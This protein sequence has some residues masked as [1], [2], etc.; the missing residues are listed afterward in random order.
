MTKAFLGGTCNHS[1]W[2]DKLI[3]I[4]NID[5]FNPVVKEWDEIAQDNEIYQR[6]TCDYVLY[7]ITPKMSG[8]YSIAE[9]VEDSIKRPKKTIFCFIENDAGFI[10]STHQI[11]SLNAVADMVKRNGAMYLSTLDDVANFLNNSVK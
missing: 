8:V 5:Y 7:V 6:A 1:N 9:V 3:P 4:L 2:R 11:K 10:F